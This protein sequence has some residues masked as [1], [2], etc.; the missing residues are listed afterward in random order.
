MQEL[1]AMEIAKEYEERAKALPLNGRQD[2]GERR[3]L[4]KELQQRCG[5]TELQAINIINGMYAIDYVK[6]QE[7]QAYIRAMEERMRSNG[8]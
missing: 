1:L 3:K 7:K 2:I 6:I 4:R 8:N 5:V